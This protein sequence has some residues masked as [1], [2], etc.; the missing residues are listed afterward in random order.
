MLVAMLRG[1]PDAFLGGNI[2]RIKAGAVLN[3]PTEQQAQASS[4]AEASQTIVAQS[5]DFNDY[6]R[7]L[8]GTAPVAQVAPADRKPRA[9]CR[10]RWKRRSPVRRAGTS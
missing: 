3:V 9:A 1:T 8:A 6:R 10:P 2:N 4:A 5:K 7:K